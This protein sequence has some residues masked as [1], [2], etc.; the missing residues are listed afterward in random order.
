MSACRKDAIRFPSADKQHTTAGWLYSSDTQ[1]PKAI[2][3]ISHGMCEYVGR[4]EDFA[5]FMVQNGYAVCG[6]DH[7]GHGATA[8][9]EADLGFFGEKDG[10]QNLLQDLYTMNRKAAERYPGV[11]LILLGHSMGSF[12]ARLYAAQYPQSISALVLS[13]TGGKRF[14]SGFGLALTS[15]LGAIRGK[16]YRSAAVTR[17]VQSGYNK[18]I[19]NPQS[20]NDWISSDT[21]LVAKYNADTHCT[22]QFTVSAYHTLISALKRCN[23]AAWAKSIPSALPVYLFS[24]DADPVGDYGKGVRSV[25]LLLKNA[26]VQDLQIKLYAGGRHEMLNET[27]KQRAYDDVL[28]WCNAHIN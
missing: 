11:P 22:F 10:L 25:Y 16:R 28:Q 9:N 4:Y 27:N 7:L 5:E 15:L 21:A 12:L 14:G 19:K 26:G 2:V 8:Q 3:Q 6:N 13:G 24:G 23:T 18:R 1:K 17:L 20:P